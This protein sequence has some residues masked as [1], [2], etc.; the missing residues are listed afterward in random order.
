MGEN[1]NP[2]HKSQLNRLN[3]ISGQLAGVKRMITEGCYCPDILMQLRAVHSAV[4][5]LEVEILKVH[6]N[7]CVVD[8]LSSSDKKVREKH[9]EEL[10]GILKKAF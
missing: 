5:S 4:K 9:I 6:I 2:S 3:R 8:A 1:C 7:A 10:T